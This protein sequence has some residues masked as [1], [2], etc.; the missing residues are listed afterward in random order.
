MKGTC[1][2][3]TSAHPV[4]LSKHRKIKIPL[5]QGMLRLQGSLGAAWL[6]HLVFPSSFL[7][8]K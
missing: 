8:S 6:H 1:P 3:A 4:L 2:E 7:Q 5:A